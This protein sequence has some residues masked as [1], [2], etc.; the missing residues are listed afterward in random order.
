MQAAPRDLPRPSL[1]LPL[2]RGVEAKFKLCRGLARTGR[3]PQGSLGK[4][5]VPAVSALPYARRF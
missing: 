3:G 1:I 2:L 4:T 5:I